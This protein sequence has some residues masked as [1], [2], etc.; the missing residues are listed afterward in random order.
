MRSQEKE[1]DPFENIT[2]QKPRCFS[3]SFFSKI[4][5]SITIMI[6]FLY[7][8]QSHELNKVESSNVEFG[9]NQYTFSIQNGTIFLMYKLQKDI[10][11]SSGDSLLLRQTILEK[12][13]APSERLFSY[14]LGYEREAFA[15]KYTSALLAKSDSIITLARNFEE[16]NLD[17]TIIHTM[18][19][20]ANTSEYPFEGRYT[21]GFFED[22]GCIMCGCDN[23]TML[24]NT[25][26]TAYSNP[27]KLKIVIAHEINHNFFETARQDDP[28]K[29]T[30]LYNAI[31][32][33]FANLFSM[34]AM[35]VDKLKAFNMSREEYEWLENHES[36]LKQEFKRVMFSSNEEDWDPFSEKVPNR[37]IEG[38]P[39]DVGYFIGFRIIELWLAKDDR[40]NWKDVYSTPVR[41]VLTES[42][43]F[44][45][46]DSH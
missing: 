25:Y 13:Y 7:C 30:V 45:Q 9:A 40:R 6:A 38:S 21:I 36:E 3:M 46:N 20:I 17:D 31:D 12:I 1:T 8:N 27:E 19:D 15:N 29:N 41:K 39:G 22:A 42:G 18:R 23:E 34:K 11:T 24:G 4:L 28:D 43:Y 14:C 10:A 26:N 16:A 2:D 35:N 37:V 33:G 5:L 32:E 44:E